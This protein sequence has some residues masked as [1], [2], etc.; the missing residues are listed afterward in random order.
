M[1]TVRMIMGELLLLLILSGCHYE[2]IQLD[3]SVC[4]IEF[5]GNYAGARAVVDDTA[6]VSLDD[7]KIYKINEGKHRV[8]VYNKDSALL[9]DRV[10]YLN[11]HMKLEVNVP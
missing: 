1:M 7:S 9:V 5:T 2:R 10:I 4:T 8:K 11:S 6:P 3:D